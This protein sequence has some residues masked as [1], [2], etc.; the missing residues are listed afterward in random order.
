M[1][2]MVADMTAR[3]DREVLIARSR[4]LHALGGQHFRAVMPFLSS[5][6]AQGH[7]KRFS[8]LRSKAWSKSHARAVFVMELAAWTADEGRSTALQRYA[9]QQT[10][11]TTSD[12]AA[13]LAG[14][15][16]SVVSFWAVQ[17]AHPVAG[18][19]VRDLLNQGTVWVVDETLEVH[20]AAGAR[21]NFLARLFRAEQDS[22]WM[23]AG[24]VVTIPEVQDIFGSEGEQGPIRAG[25]EQHAA[26]SRQGRY[27]STLYAI[28]PEAG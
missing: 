5:V 25:S 26:R 11:Q 17:E 18:W 9:R 10:I 15:Q 24:T 13:V 4:T 28:I 27:V 14:M 6:R 22:F 8:R 21:P 23:T 19:I 1:K 12:E 20:L 16:M 7:A 2:N 3:L